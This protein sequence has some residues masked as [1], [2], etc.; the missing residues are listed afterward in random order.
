MGRTTHNNTEFV[1]KFQHG[2]GVR[3]RFVTARIQG[4]KPRQVPC[5]FETD[6]TTCSVYGGSVGSLDHDKFLVSEFTV[7][8]HYKDVHNQKLARKNAVE[9][10]LA[11]LDRETRKA[12]LKSLNIRF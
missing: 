9:G 6:T 7:A 1:V 5:E 3:T 4:E 12:I 10:A 8:R 11:G 2:K